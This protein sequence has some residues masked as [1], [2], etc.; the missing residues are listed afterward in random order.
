MKETETDRQTERQ[1]DR[2]TEAERERGGGGG[3]YLGMFGM[4]RLGQGEKKRGGGGGGG[5]LSIISLHC[6]I[7]S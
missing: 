2:D 3:R 5:R 6:Q 1:T 7:P 4:W